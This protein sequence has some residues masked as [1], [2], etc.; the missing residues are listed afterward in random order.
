MEANEKGIS[1][2]FF[3]KLRPRSIMTRNMMLTSLYIIL[4]GAVLIA[5]SY[6]I[7]GDV[8]VKQLHSESGKIMEKWAGDLPLEEVAAAKGSIDPTSDIQKKITQFFDDL[9]STHPNIAQG[10]IFGPEL[11][12]DNKT[13]MIAFP[14]A[15]LQMFEEAGL[16]LGDYYEQPDIHVAGVKK[17][18]ETKELT[19]TSSYKDDY[20]TWVTVLHPYLDASGNVIA[21]MGMD[22]D[23]SLVMQGKSELLKNTLLALLITLLVVLSLQYIT[24]RKTFAPVKELMNALEKLSRGDFNVQLKEGGD[25]LGQVNAKFNT[26]IVTINNLISTMKAVSSASADESKVLFSTVELNNA[27]TAVI[28]KS[29]E[30]LSERTVVQNTTI[31]E[32]VTSLEEITSGV[33]AIADNASE[34]AETSLQMKLQSEQG[35]TNMEQVVSQMNSINTSVKDSVRIIEKL[36]IRSDEIEQ[37][38]QLITQIA[39]QT[40]LLSLNASIEAA[41]AGENGRGF[42]VVANEVKKLAEQSKQSADQIAMLIRTIQEETSQAVSAIS[43]GEQNVEKGIEIVKETGMLFNNIYIAT[44]SV[45][46]QIQEVS[47]ATEEMVAVSEQITASFKQL[48]A[49]SE[50]N[51]E[52]TEAIKLKA[53]AQQASFSRIVQSAEQLNEVSSQLENLVVDLVV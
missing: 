5:Y 10:Y 26:T 6:Y 34:L 33:N 11:V 41:R 17:M 31:S 9:S 12:D 8:L 3:G 16:K 44:D 37:I 1:W 32:S 19:F 36:Q 20:G 14:T 43:L 40:N 53:Q 50:Q 24:N 27:D 23:A 22:V 18:L 51:S 42:A 38:V 7:Q 35:N 49:M 30:E 39:T 21:Y 52:V 47:A 28:T 29:M 2:S 25:E 4:T 45:T 48:A 46:S 15:V 13:S